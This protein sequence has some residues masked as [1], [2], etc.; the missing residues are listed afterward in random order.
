MNKIQDNNER[1]YSPLEERINIVSHGI[2]FIFSI[3]ALISLVLHSAMNG[4]LIDIISFSIFG[5]S[6]ILLYTASTVYH[7]SKE[8]K[9]RRRLRVFDHASIYV[10]I[11]GTYTPFALITFGGTIGWFIFGLTWGIALIGI[12]LKLFYTGRFKILS[13]LMYIA[14]GWLIIFFIQPLTNNLSSTGL[15]WLL[16]GGLSYTIGAVIYAIKKI[17]FNHATFHIFVLAGSFSHFLAVY[18]YV[19]PH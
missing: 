13:T 5:L 9:V 1:I 7:S 15:I 17:K 6:L 4:D 16:I 19:L 14:M 11:A 2:G 3:L 10:L 8:K 12:I 18:L